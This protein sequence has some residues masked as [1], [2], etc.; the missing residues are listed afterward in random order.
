MAKRYPN[1]PV[2]PAAS[3][4]STR[5]SMKGN[6]SKGT[7]AEIKLGAIL[8]SRGLTGYSAN[9]PEMPG[10][11]D[12]AFWDE[13][14]AVFV[15]GCYWHRCPYCKPNFPKSNREYWSAKFQRNRLRDAQNRSD[16]RSMG[17]KPVVV[18]ECMLSKNPKRVGVR[19]Q[20]ALE[21]A[22]A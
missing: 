21:E 2:S 22:R 7:T 6:R 15:N 16:L 10:S 13:R 20:R 9:D 17:W 4:A 1:L 11:P 8:D 19:L 18:W 14:V 12:F 3:T 5:A